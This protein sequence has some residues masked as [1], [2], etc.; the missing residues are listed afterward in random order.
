MT[1]QCSHQQPDPKLK[2]FRRA[3]WRMLLATMFCYMF[4]YTGRQNWGF[5]VQALEKDLG[6]D[7]VQ[8]GWIAGAMLAVYG[9]GQ[10]INGN[11]GDKFGGRRMVSLGAVLSCILVWATS[12]G[13][14]FYTLLIPWALNGYAQSLG[15]APAGR[16]ISN[17]WGPHEKAKAFG[18]YTFGA[19]TSSVLIFMLCIL[20]LQAGMSW[21]W[22]FR[23]PVL[24]LA[25]AGVFYYIIVRDA[26]EELGFKSPNPQE[27]GECGPQAGCDAA[28]TDERAANGDEETSVQ[29]YLATLSNW[30]FLAACVSLGFE[31][32]A[33]YGLLIW[34]PVYYLGEGW[35]S[36]PATVWITLALPIGMAFGALFGGQLSDNYFHSN[37]S[38]P[39]ILMMS[40]A[41]AVSLFMYFL[42][43]EQI[44]LAI[45]LLFLTGFLVYGPQS[46]F[47]ALC[48]DLLGAKRAGTGVGVMDAAA[49]SFAAIQ[50]PV[51]GWVIVTWG[52]QAVFTTIA[53]ACLLSVVT[54]LP[55]RK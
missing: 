23:L 43:Q 17:W 32:M 22:V 11:L 53:A 13:Y 33:R 31:S 10:F 1:L 55:V 15:W 3:Q 44:I 16:L 6:L 2:S 50:G 47:W 37:R 35:Q 54:I 39:I 7:K 20:I 18:V 38:K 34:V 25:V 21:Q 14:S 12:L 28:K 30:R 41:A 24:L 26:P 48:P 46:S 52:E 49:Y 45:G 27:Q 4:Y 29:R 8:T 42:P 19:A 40:F 51:F 9:V 36:S 5:V